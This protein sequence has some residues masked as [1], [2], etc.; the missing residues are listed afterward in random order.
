MRNALRTTL[1]GGCN[2][3][4]RNIVN[5]IKESSDPN[6]CV[7]VTANDGQI[8]EQFLRTFRDNEKTIPTILTTSRKLSTGVDAR[9]VRN[10][11]LMRPIKSMIEFKQI[12]SFHSIKPESF[13]LEMIGSETSLDTHHLFNSDESSLLCLKYS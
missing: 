8:G 11:V 3:A 9:N 2:L 4:V 10:I 1:L 5:Q 7:R 6:Y 12:S 13:N